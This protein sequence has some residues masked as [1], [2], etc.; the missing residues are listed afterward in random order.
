VVA[1]A[2]PIDA[3]SVSG[4][5]LAY[6]EVGEIYRYSIP[7]HRRVPL[8]FLAGDPFGDFGDLLLTGKRVW[9]S[10]GSAG[11]SESGW[12]LRSALRPGRKPTLDQGLYQAGSGGTGLAGWDGIGTTFVYATV[13]LLGDD[14]NY[15]GGNATV[16]GSH[17]YRVSMSSSGLHTNEVPGTPGGADVA[18]SSGRV[19]LVPITA[20]GTWSSES[21]YSTTVEIRDLA[22]GALL[23]TLQAQHWVE[24][25][26]LSHS[27]AVFLTTGPGFSRWWIERY[28]L[29]TG[30]RLGVA[31]IPAPDILAGFAMSGNRVVY[32]TG[33]LRSRRREIWLMRADSG[34]TKVLY[35]NP[36]VRHVEI[37]GNRVF[38]VEGGTDLHPN[39]YRI[40]ELALGKAR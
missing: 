18:V 2:Y 5:H 7:R 40:Q 25:I 31:S 24:A 9:W 17:L 15:S 10:E 29:A 16:T 28:S 38:W 36:W 23:R 12:A 19:A 20:G 30:E 22:T 32:I 35:R 21:G 3:F 33:D 39:R 6:L 37:E 26:G 11:N 27:L 4:S 34:K 8:A 13:D 1:T 14:Y